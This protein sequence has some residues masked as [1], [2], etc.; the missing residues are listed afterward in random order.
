MGL[1]NY[2]SRMR[3]ADM[4]VQVDLEKRKYKKVNTSNTYFAVYHEIQEIDSKAFENC[5]N[6][7][8]LV[9]P[10]QTL[11]IGEYAFATCK[12][13]KTI[14]I[15]VNNEC[16]DVSDWSVISDNKIVLSDGCF[17]G[18]AHLINVANIPLTAGPFFKLYFKGL[19]CYA[20]VDG[21]K[22][23]I[24]IDNWNY[25]T[26]PKNKTFQKELALYLLLLIT[27]SSGLEKGFPNKPLPE[28]ELKFVY[29]DKIS[30]GISDIVL[31]R[32]WN[33]NWNKKGIPSME[34]IEKLSLEK[35]KLQIK[36]KLGKAFDEVGNQDLQRLLKDIVRTWKCNSKNSWNNAKAGEIDKATNIVSKEMLFPIIP[37]FVT[38]IG[39]GAFDNWTCIEEVVIPDYINK[40]QQGAF[41]ECKNLKKVYVPQNGTIIE[42]GAFSNDTKIVLV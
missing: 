30:D 38:Q 37:P 40:I 8:T 5:S 31:K 1:K 34:K 15:K 9:L 24:K 17:G 4:D 16:K 2:C 6:L 11:K 36:D 41:T 22:E 10:S 3:L 21:N 14:K 13:L 25:T 7:Q 32:I 29:D 39:R 18:C 19:Q 23:G 33:N 35:V 28:L 26:M 20:E 42:N 27:L 12:K